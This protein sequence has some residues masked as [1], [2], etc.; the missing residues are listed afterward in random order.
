MLQYFVNKLFGDLPSSFNYMIG[1]KIEYDIKISYYEIYEGHDKNGEEVCVFIYEKNNKETKI[2]HPNILKV[3]DTYENEKRIYIVTEKC[4]PLI[5]EKIK[6]DP[7]WGLYEIMRCIH[8]IN[9]CNYIHGLIN[10]LSIFVNSKGRWKLSNFDC[11]HEKNMSICNI[12]NDIKDH[13]FCSYGYKINIPNNIHST[14]I[15]CNGLILL[16]IW[17]YKKYICSTGS[18]NDEYMFYENGKNNSN[19]VMRNMSKVDGLKMGSEKNDALFTFGNNIYNKNNVHNNT[20]S[21]MNY[22]SS[23]PYSITF[24]IFNVNYKKDKME[25][26]PHNLHKIYDMLNTYNC[27]EIDLNKIL[28]DENL[29]NNNHIVRTMLFLTEIHMRSKI[30]KSIFLDNL[31]KHIDNI[32]LDVKVQMILPELCKNIDIFENY[33]KCLKI[34]LHISKDIPSDEFEKMVY[35]PI[36]LKCFH[37]TDRTDNLNEITKSG[38]PLQTGGDLKKRNE[39][40]G[41]TNN[42]MEHIHINGD[43][44]TYL[45]KKN[46]FNDNRKNNVDY[47]QFD[48]INNDQFFVDTWNPNNIDYHIS[49]PKENMKEENK[50]PQFISDTNLFNNNNIQNNVTLKEQI[51]EERPLPLHNNNNNNMNWGATN[52]KNNDSVHREDKN[53]NFFK[54]T[55]ESRMIDKRYK[56]KINMDIDNFF[57]EFD[58][59]KEN[60][61][62][63]VKLSSLQ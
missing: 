60:N 54:S 50:S 20:C 42:I 39:F 38:A 5:Y 33:I 22:L 37:L 36:F 12:Y 57:D 29:K 61:T 53:H 18:M 40:I 34:I 13:I 59:S 52:I 3:L 44:S 16:M 55:G 4:V 2:I 28:N 7:I 14:Y 48:N 62:P 45:D 6:S 47:S 10:P 15:D 1:K 19:N 43:E 63:K 8:F 31:F 41:D 25:Y 11:I 27:V 56:N 23:D 17:S 51:K 26:I 49:L 46:I 24:P 32:S 21:M 35:G 9:S 58:L 30:E